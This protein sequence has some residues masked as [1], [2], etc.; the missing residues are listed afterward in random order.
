MQII[1]LLE[2]LQTSSALIKLRRNLWRSQI[3]T[4]PS[5]RKSHTTPVIIRIN[6]LI[7]CFLDQPTVTRY[8]IHNRT[9]DPFRVTAKKIKLNNLGRHRSF[10]TIQSSKLKSMR[11]RFIKIPLVYEQSLIINVRFPKHV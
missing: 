1:F 7:I 8:K 11:S 2:S 6:Y 9:F 3:K 5:I 4:K 10:I